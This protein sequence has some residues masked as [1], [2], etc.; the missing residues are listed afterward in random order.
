M[1]DITN[2]VIGVTQCWGIFVSG[3]WHSLSSGFLLASNFQIFCLACQITGV[4][5]RCSSDPVGCPVVGGSATM[6]GMWVVLLLFN[7]KG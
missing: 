6:V 5:A 4:P 1:Y 2:G 7:Q 3:G